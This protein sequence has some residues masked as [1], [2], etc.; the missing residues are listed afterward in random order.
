LDVVKA[1]LLISY[2]LLKLFNLILEPATLSFSD[3]FQV[4]LGL[5]LLVFDINERLSVHELHLSG[6]EM[7]IEDLE[8]LLVLFY[9]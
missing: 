8:S 9:L 2:S 1:V 5:D 4:L 6:L 7:L 3:L